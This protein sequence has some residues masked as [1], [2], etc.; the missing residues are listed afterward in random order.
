MYIHMNSNK[1]PYL[2]CRG[3]SESRKPYS[4]QTPDTCPKLYTILIL[5]MHGSQRPRK[6]LGQR[7]LM[8]AMRQAV[9]GALGSVWV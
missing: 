8:S 3:V 4:T 1:F 7:S 5:R 2:L 9:Y 6:E